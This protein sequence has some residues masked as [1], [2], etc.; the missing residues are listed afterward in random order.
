MVFLSDMFS[1]DGLTALVTGCAAGIGSGLALG[2]AQA[3]ATVIGLDIKGME[4]T[5]HHIAQKGGS[6]HGYQVDLSDEEA[7]NSCWDTVLEK[8]ETIDI[9]VNNAGTQYRSPASEFPLEAFDKIQS[10]NL[11]APYQLS[12]LAVQH[13]LV[14][15]KKGKI[16]NI[17]S[18][19][20]TFGGVNVSAYTCSK[21][22]VLGMTRAFSNEYAGNGI[23]VNA[24]APGYIATEITKPIWSDRAKSEPIDQRIPIGRWGSPQDFVGV[25][26]FLA[27][28]A[29]DYITGAMIPVDGGYAIR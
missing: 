12:Q 19:F 10:I 6:F 27:S 14:Q 9:L 1:L 16:I 11:R 13:F 22:G 23:T 18:L 26:V 2:L 25:G 20:S 24:I 21:H 3:G 5:A 8:H 29:S 7:L 15:K 28:H 4:E 17:A